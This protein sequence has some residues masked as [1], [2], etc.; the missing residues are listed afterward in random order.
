MQ[1]I[2]QLDLEIM[3]C[4]QT[5]TDIVPFSTVSGNLNMVYAADMVVQGLAQRHAEKMAILQQLA[6]E[7]YQHPEPVEDDGGPLQLADL[8]DTPPPSPTPA[9]LPALAPL[10]YPDVAYPDVAYPIG[11]YP[12]YSP[13]GMD[14]D[15]G[16]QDDNEPMEMETARSIEIEVEEGEEIS[17]P[18]HV[19]ARSVRRCRRVRAIPME[20]G[21]QN[22]KS[23]NVC[24]ETP[25]FQDSY[26][27]SCGHSFCKGC[28]EQWEHTC[29]NNNST[30]SCPTCRTRRPVLRLYESDDEPAA[31]IGRRRS[32]VFTV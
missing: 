2:Q 26:L 1:R 6:T 13:G 24:F 29:L 25:D 15:W 28:F 23:C 11:Q 22:E 16:N 14:P 18:M 5:L 4:I 30:V 10:A 17:L 12:A 7:N 31:G 27:T 20:S 3:R 9:P 32:R 19:T 8:M 21:A